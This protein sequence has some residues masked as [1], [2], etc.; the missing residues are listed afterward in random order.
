M[1]VKGGPLVI[2][3]GI[4]DGP[5][6]STVCHRAPR[7][8]NA[9]NPSD[10]QCLDANLHF[11]PLDSMLLA[12]SPAKPLKY[13]L[14]TLKRRLHRCSAQH[15]GTSMRHAMQLFRPSFKHQQI[16]DTKRSRRKESHEWKSKAEIRS[17]LAFGETP[18]LTESGSP[19]SGSGHQN[20]TLSGG[21]GIYV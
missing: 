11:R 14:L 4:M 17:R 5:M 9:T 15:R 10:P 6:T 8:R 3:Q 18:P 16:R 19:L 12:V 13:P 1:A 7:Q 2:C 20:S 21:R